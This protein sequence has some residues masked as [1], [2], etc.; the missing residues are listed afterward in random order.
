MQ[1]IGNTSKND[2]F[3]CQ[4]VSLSLGGREILNNVNL[5]VSP[6]EILG[7]VGPQGLEA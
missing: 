7:V 6:G 2:I 4:D 3:C 5:E 1:S